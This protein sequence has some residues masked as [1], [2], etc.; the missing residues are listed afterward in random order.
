MLRFE[1]SRFE[2]AAAAFAPVCGPSGDGII[3]RFRRSECLSRLG[4]HDEAVAEAQRAHED[5]PDVPAT[6][7]WLAQA[8]AEA[9][10]HA[11][12]AAVRFP[13]A[14]R[15]FLSPVAAAWDAVAKLASG[16]TTD[17]AAVRE[18]IL[19]SRHAPAYSVAI[20][21]AETD[22]LVRGPRAPDLP[23][24]WYREE[25]AEEMREDGAT[26]HAP[27]PRIATGQGF[28]FER[29]RRF[30]AKDAERW[31]RLHT[32]CGDWRALVA[33]I[34]AARP[35]DAAIDEVELEMLLAAGDLDAADALAEKLAKDAGDEAAGELAVDRC[36][37]AQLRGRAAR[38][39]D[40]AG[41]DDAKRRLGDAIAWLDC[42]ASIL[43]GDATGARTAADRVSDPSH[44]EYV[45]A[46]LL[47]WVQAIGKSIDG[48][49]DPSARHIA[50]T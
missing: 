26:E 11:D 12:A 44:R 49:G 46:A 10:R 22:R 19:A 3:A 9:G 23:S 35:A 30:Q 1:E 36:R 2:E 15:E 16:A 28:L 24:V 39:R 41:F 4:R 34:R 47:R 8:L 21:L 45:D 38:P 42:C 14:Q 33:Q 27:P 43:E 17:R 48:A 7:V 20:R 50:A 31:L 13:D 5:A 40:F 29:L 32:A 18:A 37:I 6:G 25:C